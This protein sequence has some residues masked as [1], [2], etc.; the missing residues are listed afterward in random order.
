MIFVYSILFLISFL[1]YNVY[2]LYLNYKDASALGLPR[3][4]SPITPD[5]PLWIALQTIFKTVVRQFPFGAVSFTRHTRLGWEFHDKFHTHVRLGDA[6]VLVTPTRNWIFVA[7]AATVT[8]IFSRG[9]DFVRPIWMLEAL[10]VFGPNIST[11]EGHDW[12]RRRKLTATPF[13]EQKSPQVWDESFRQ[14]EDMLQSWCSQ[15]RD[16]TNATP[17][18]TRTLALHV[19]AYVAFQKSYP[20]GSISHHTIQDQDSLTYRDSISIILENALLI[21]VLPEK[22]FK[23]AILATQ[24]SASWVG[25]QFVPQLYGFQVAAERRLIQNGESGNGNLVSNL[26][27]ASN[28]SH[29]T[30]LDPGEDNKLKPLTNAEILGN[31]F[32]FNFAGHDTTAISLSYAMLL[33]VA[34]PQVQDWVREEIKYYVGGR[35]PKTLAYSELFPKLKRSLAVLLETLRL[36]NPLPGIPKYTGSKS[37]DLVVNDQTYHIPA[38]YL[39]VP[40]LQALHTHPHHWGGD[41]LTWRPERWI[42]NSGNL[43]KES[44]FN[45]PKGTYFPWSEG[46]RNCPGKRFAQVE[47]V[48]TLTAL[49][50]SHTAEPVPNKGESLDAARKRT[51]D[52]VKDSNVELLLQMANPRSVSIRWR[53]RPA[54]K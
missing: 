31:I 23:S 39:V 37:T 21:M 25:N 35:D 27:R 13:N 8:D 44:L 15:S 46:I 9:R 30:S 29:S 34:N 50:R 42:E 28:E 7:N 52:T 16:G 43:E 2:S 26:V 3:V 11:A 38:N 4:I 24:L 54:G 36:Y 49:F 6:W 22:L 12:Q 47:F 1:L 33:L 45:P 5:N 19:L 41:S 32:V 40:H 14:A 51:L 48:A 20:F 53:Q 18:D 17:D 10:N